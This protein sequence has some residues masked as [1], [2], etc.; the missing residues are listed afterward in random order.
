M[1][2]PSKDLPTSRPASTPAPTTSA[3]DMSA[4]RSCHRCARR[5]SSLKYDRHSI[6]L[7]CRDVECSLDVR[8]SECSSWSSDFMQDYLK[9]KKSLISKRKKKPVSS[10]PSSSP[11]VSLAVSTVA[12]VGSPIAL[13]SVS[14]DAKIK[15]YVHLILS[16]FFSQSGSVGINPSSLS[17][18]TVVPDS[19][20]PIRGGC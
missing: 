1:A 7:Q 2:S 12:S 18:P 20:P 6:C 8:C 14:D 5:M 17:A 16:S 19:A 10:A 15:D 3:V 4:H 11:S 13:P 9:H